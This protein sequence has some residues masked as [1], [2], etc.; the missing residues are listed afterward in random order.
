MI[1]TLSAI[2]Q[3]LNWCLRDEVS[4]NSI[5]PPN[6]RWKIS[7]ILVIPALIFHTIK[8]LDE[9]KKCQA[10]KAKTERTF[11]H[12]LV[13]GGIPSWCQI[14]VLKNGFVGSYVK[15]MKVC[16]LLQC[17]SQKYL[18]S[19]MGF[20]LWTFAPPVLGFVGGGLVDSVP[21]WCIPS[22][23]LGLLCTAKFKW[24]KKLHKST[25]YHSPTVVYNFK[26]G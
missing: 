22:Q 6:Q 17:A 11:S 5:L 19:F 25:N 2:Y 18:K 15:T 20:L 1:K 21:R 26:C 14:L 7:Q 16:E 23:Q 9:L 4:L 3:N 12:G 10:P 8:P 13:T 24:T